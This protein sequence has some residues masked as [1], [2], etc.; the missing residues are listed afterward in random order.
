M[1][2]PWK[3]VW[4]RL[5]KLKIEFLYDPTIPR[6]GIDPEETLIQKDTCTPVFTAALFT[7]AKTWQGFPGG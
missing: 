2:L 6:L 5:K 3:I 1:Q 4:R 7:A